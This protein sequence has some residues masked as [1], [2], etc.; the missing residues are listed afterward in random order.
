MKLDDVYEVYDIDND[1]KKEGRSGSK[2][3]KIT[4]VKKEEEAGAKL[5]ETAKSEIKPRQKKKFWN[6]TEMGN[7]SRKRCTLT[8]PL[9]TAK[10]EIYKMPGQ[11]GS[12]SRG[13]VMKPKRGTPSK[14]TL[15]KKIEMFETRASQGLTDLDLIRII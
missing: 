9:F 10:T 3:K 5:L 8:E 14:L 12:P 4:V 7:T 6:T 13:R 1:R 15:R 2:K 11:G